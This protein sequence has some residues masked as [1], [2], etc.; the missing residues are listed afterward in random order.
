MKTFK[1][2]AIFSIFALLLSS[3]LTTE[4]KEYTW[5]LT[6]EK[7]GTLTIKYYNIM[8]DTDPES[9]DAT[10]VQITTDYNEMMDSYIN[11]TSL[12]DEYP[13]ALSVDKR[14]YEE[15]GVLCGEVV[16]KFDDLS[17][18]KVY[19][20]DSKCPMMFSLQSLSSETFDSSNGEQGPD[21]FS[22]VIWKPGMKTLTLKTSVADPAE[23]GNY[24]LLGK[25]KNPDA[26]VK[27][28]PKGLGMD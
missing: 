27:K 16:V 25:W 26:P 6:G 24:S 21:Y 8:S 2:L 13:N 18:V 5:V 7:S 1:F 19:Q 14:L 3:C 11:G 17:Q 20:Y 28:A 23:D 9:E 15:N 22:A 10:D 4:Y 12:T